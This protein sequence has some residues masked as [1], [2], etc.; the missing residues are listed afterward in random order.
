MYGILIEDEFGMTMPEVRV[1]LLNKGVD[2]RTFFIPM[3]K[4]PVYK[5]NKKPNFPDCSGLY[6]VAE[7]LGE[8]GLYL[9]SASHLTK[10]QIVE[11]VGAI[12]GL[13]K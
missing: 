8:M 12:K 11:I 10:E 13:K 3:H 4:Q 5:T 2:T 7:M 9:P 6:P 1:A